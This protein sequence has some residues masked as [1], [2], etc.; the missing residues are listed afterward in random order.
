MVIDECRKETIITTGKKILH[1]N[2][3]LTEFINNRVQIV[4]EGLLINTTPLTTLK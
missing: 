4:T 1:G 3:N 2:G